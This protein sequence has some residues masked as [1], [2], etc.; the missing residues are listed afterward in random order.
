M[1]EKS[2]YRFHVR[3]DEWIKEELK[4]IAKEKERPLNWVVVDLIKKGLEV[5]KKDTDK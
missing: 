1:A 5:N 4:K 2:E 3:M